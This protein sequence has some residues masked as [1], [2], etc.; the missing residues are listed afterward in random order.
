VQNALLVH[1]GGG[2]VCQLATARV[3]TRLGVDDVAAL[4]LLL[5]VEL[6]QPAARTAALPSTTTA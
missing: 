5:L 2:L 3:L 1:V 4:D 6:P